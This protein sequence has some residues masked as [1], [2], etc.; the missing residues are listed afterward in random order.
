MTTFTL[1]R[2]VMRV[3]QTTTATREANTTKAIPTY[4]SASLTLTPY[5]NGTASVLGTGATP[6]SMS[7]SAVP[8]MP[9]GAAS[10][11]CMDTVGWAAMV[12]LAGLVAM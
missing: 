4:A 6:S 8:M 11:V 1:T 10:R 2:T 12:G 5:I 3:V 9:T 7:T